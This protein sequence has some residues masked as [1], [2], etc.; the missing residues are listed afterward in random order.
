MPKVTLVP[1]S[2]LTPDNQNANRHTVRGN[3]L[4]RTS[5]EQFGPSRDAIVLDKHGNI[6]GGNARSEVFADKQMDEV[7]VIEGLDCTKPVALKFDDLD[8]SDEDNPARLLS[9]ALNRTAQVNIDFDFEVLANYKEQGIKLDD[10]FFE[11]EL[12]KG[13]EIAGDEILPPEDFNSYDEEVKTEYCCPKCGF[14]WSG[15]PK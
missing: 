11:S 10:F 5:I 7:Q 14:S 2:N 1:L 6:V 13:L 12:Q 9:V 3:H 8:L 4:L 15:K